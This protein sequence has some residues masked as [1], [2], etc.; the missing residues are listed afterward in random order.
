MNQRNFAQVRQETQLLHRDVLT[1]D[2][3]IIP[4][5]QLDPLAAVAVDRLRTGPFDPLR[6]FSNVENW[7][8]DAK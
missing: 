8:L 1:L 7:R 2:M 3:P 6:V 4:L 5:W